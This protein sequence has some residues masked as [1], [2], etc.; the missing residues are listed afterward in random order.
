MRFRRRLRTLALLAGLTA[1]SSSSPGLALAQDTTSAN[2]IAAREHFEK[3]R[4]YYGQ[5]AYREAVAE[6]EAAHTLDP[7][8]KDLVFNLG[9][10]HEKLSDIDDALE[11][12][13]LYTTMSLT[14]Q[15]RERADAYIKRL[16]GA[17]KELAQKSQ[18]D[19]SPPAL[20]GPNPATTAEPPPTL[21]PP[22]P[23]RRGR[24]D[25]ATVLA[26]GVAGGAAIFATVLGIKALSDR[27]ANGFILGKDGS[28]AQLNDRVDQAHDE[29]I[30]ADMGFG[31]SIAAAAAATVLYFGRSRIPPVSSPAASGS[32]KVSVTPRVGGGALV[33]QGSF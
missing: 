20:S 5:G 18:S 17:K 14:P 2:V 3:A 22:A 7:S 25:A 27:P 15:E 6:L 11:W 8:A 29:A 33:V 16:E 32:P 4:A 26:A 10:V 9:V 12:F 28:L 30:V 24:V 13:E 19:E 31:V 21:G 23:S 1:G